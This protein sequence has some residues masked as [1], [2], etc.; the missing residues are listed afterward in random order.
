[1]QRRLLGERGSEFVTIQTR[2]DAT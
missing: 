1:M 2:A